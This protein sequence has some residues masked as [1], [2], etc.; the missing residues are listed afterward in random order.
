V[1]R[2]AKDNPAM[3]E[4]IARTGGDVYLHTLIDLDNQARLW[5]GKIVAGAT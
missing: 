3:R 2:G 5:I 1:F 4:E